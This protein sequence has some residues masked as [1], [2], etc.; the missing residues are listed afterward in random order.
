MDALQKRSTYQNQFTGVMTEKKV[1]QAR[2]EK[3]IARHADIIA[4]TDRLR[5]EMGAVETQIRTNADEAETKQQSAKQVETEREALAQA[6]AALRKKISTFEENLGKKDSH[7]LLLADMERQLEG[8]NE[9]TKAVINEINTE[10]CSLKGILGT[11]PDLIQ[12]DAKYGVAVEA[13]L[14]D[15]TDTFITKTLQDAMSMLQFGEQAGHGRLHAVA[16][17]SVGLP[18]GTPPVP[19]VTGLVP[20]ADI[21]TCDPEVRPAVASL[22][23][24]IYIAESLVQA[25]AAVDGNARDFTVVTLDGD[26]LSPT[27]QMSAGRAAAQQ[28]VISRRAELKQLERETGELA[29][30][31]LSLKA[32]EGRTAAIVEAKEREAKELRM[33]VYELKAAGLELK[34]S[35]DNLG[36][37][38]QMYTDEQKVNQIEQTETESRIASANE[39]EAALGTLIAEC[40]ALYDA[41]NLEAENL[42]KDLAQIGA[43]RDANND[44]LTELKVA[45]SGLREKRE[46]LNKEIAQIDAAVKDANNGLERATTRLGQIT[47]QTE[48]TKQEIAEL[49]AKSEETNRR[50]AEQTE[51]MAALR[52]Q[53]EEISPALTESRAQLQAVQKE[54][55]ELQPGIQDARFHESEA[56]LKLEN[57]VQRAREEQY[58]DNLPE[59]FAAWTDDGQ[60]NWDQLVI[61]IDELVRKVHSIGDINMSAI[62]QLKETEEKLNFY[63]TQQTDLVQSKESLEELIKKLNKESREMFMSTLETVRQNF[64]QVFRKLFGG[65]KTDIILEENVDILDAGIDVMAKPPGKEFTSITLLSGGER[66]LT[67][68]ALVMSI[69]MLKPS[70]FCLMDEVDAPL[71]ESNVDR[72]IG[73]IQEYASNTQFILITHNKR[74]MASANVLFGVTMEEQGVSKKISMKLVEEEVAVC[75]EA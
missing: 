40:Q 37:R 5:Q 57:I 4:E 22:L 56:N 12:I 42:A 44:L 61:D 54:L 25:L 6:L 20:A 8:R 32:E 33:A 9:A 70:P 64:N 2:L 49:A 45:L 47:Q 11:L 29:T 60:T 17:N 68:F 73:L 65:G 1:F 41:I 30:Q 71:D 26:V 18:Q 66:A 38:V 53:I 35:L 7:R 39:K 34:G 50:L 74:T 67:T 3:I 15:A 36:K 51:I 69:F 14:P 24:G 28:N 27:G 55:D 52:K 10:S 58:A 21:V 62:E 48:T 19:P 16:L 23:S 72:F 75:A 63:T 46:S 31:L 59:Q 13:A 43:Q